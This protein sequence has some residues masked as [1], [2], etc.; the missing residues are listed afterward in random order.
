[1]RPRYSLA[2]R[3]ARQLL[4]QA[5]VETPPVPLE[6]LAQ[7]CR[8]IIRYEPFE[9]ELSGIAH[10]RS[11]GRGLIGVNSF[12]SSTR[13]RFTIA[14][15]IGHLLL[16]GDEEIH[17]DEKRNTF[18]RRDEISSQAT[19]PREI[20]ANQFAAELLMPEFLIRQ[21]LST[22]VEENPKISVDAAIERLASE[23]V[24]SQLAMT[25]RL[26]N[27]RIINSSDAVAG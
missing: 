27:L 19:D 21:S 23:Y 10:R 17:I 26:T 24:V 7:L 2:R 6:Y 5:N 15:E 12:H 20:E 22:L 1:M 11:D 13:Q 16:H 9:G 4:E 8:A 25:H 3:R 14:H 18:G